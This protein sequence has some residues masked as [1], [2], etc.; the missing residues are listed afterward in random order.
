MS[1]DLQR[2]YDIVRAERHSN[3][4]LLAGGRSVEHLRAATA[5]FVLLDVL[6]ILEGRVELGQE[7]EVGQDVGVQVRDGVDKVGEGE[8]GEGRLQEGKLN[9]CEGRQDRPNKGTYMIVDKVARRGL[10]RLKE[11]LVLTEHL[12]DVGLDELGQE[13]GL[14]RRVS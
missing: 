11:R 5:G 4:R 8:L 12:R 3:N 14:R 6:A 2:L 13:R 9:G 10:G 7:R 1:R